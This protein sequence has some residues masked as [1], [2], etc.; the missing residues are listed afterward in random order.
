MNARVVYFD[1][2]FPELVRLINSFAGADFEVDYL[3]QL[4]SAKGAAAIRQADYFLVAAE[5]ITAE[6]I[7][8]APD[9][10]LIQKTGAGYDNINVKTA[11]I[12][13]V[14]V[15][16]TPGVNATGVAELTIAHILAL[17][18]KLTLLDN[19]CK[20]GEWPMWEYRLASHEMS[21]KVHGIIGFG[22][23]GQYVARLSAAFGTRIV[24]YDLYQAKSELAVALRA[25]YLSLDQLLATADI[26]SLHL[27][28]TPETKD[29]VG[30]REL[31][32]M[33]QSAVIVNMARGGIVN[34]AALAQALNGGRIAGA[35]FDTLS[36]EP[37]IAGNQLL[38]AANFHCTPHIG[39]GTRETLDRVL[40]LAFDNL[41]LVESGQKPNF[42]I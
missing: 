37:Q 12:R 29:L 31:A 15:C 40:G 19:R 7:N 3:K 14:P 10:K 24:Y 13:G 38:K 36:D 27:P 22:K 6:I 1:P 30:E 11:A 41:R 42:I 34:E 35:A 20:R 32:S 23:I 26:I 8:A 16:N 21:G 5:K 17:Y 33:K 28:L 25:K 18:R 4:D 9:L 39:A 2:V